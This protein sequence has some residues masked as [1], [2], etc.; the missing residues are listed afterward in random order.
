MCDRM[1]HQRYCGD[2]ACRMAACVLEDSGPTYSDRAVAST[3]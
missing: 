2:S 3:L 1:P